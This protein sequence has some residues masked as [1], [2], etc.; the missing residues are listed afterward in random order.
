MKGSW[1]AKTRGFKKLG[2]LLLCGP[3]ISLN[4]GQFQ[5]RIKEYSRNMIK[6]R[7]RPNLGLMKAISRPRKQEKKEHKKIEPTRRRKAREIKKTRLYQEDLL[8]C[9]EFPS[10]I[11][12]KS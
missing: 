3:I 8:I 2:D 4:L 1:P 5:P 6:E 11:K 9:L 7:L 10:Y 12:V